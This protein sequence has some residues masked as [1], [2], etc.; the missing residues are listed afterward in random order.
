MWLMTG[1]GL[2]SLKSMA[3]R[4]RAWYAL[5][6]ME[7]SVV[8]LTIRYVDKIR[9]ETLSLVICRIICKIL[10]ALRSPFLWKVEQVGFD[11]ALRISRIA[12]GWGNVQASAWMQ[13]L[14]FIKYLGIRA[15][16]NI[17]G[18]DQV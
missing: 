6:R 18:W 12:V 9:S 2:A 1:G 15:V 5:S 7:R 10:K 13:D 4:R 8:D 3:L 14:G 11:L 16:N 17:G